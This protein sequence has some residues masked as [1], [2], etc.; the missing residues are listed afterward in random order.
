[1]VMVHTNRGLCALGPSD[2]LHAL[3]LVISYPAQD[4]VTRAPLLTTCN[5][6]ACV[7]RPVR[8]SY[9][10]DELGSIHFSR[11]SQKLI[12]IRYLAS[13][14]LVGILSLSLYPLKKR[15]VSAGAQTASIAAYRADLVRVRTL[16]SARQAPQ[17]SCH[18]GW[19]QHL[20]NP[21]APPKPQGLFYG[22]QNSLFQVWQR[23]CKS[24]T[25]YLR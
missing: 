17:Y 10:L 25:Q 16:L 6:R 21:L 13:E 15:F 2:S 11:E 9:P 19:L 20:Y 18:D 24:L 1:M 8:V 3:R 4:S 23:D 22:L 7:L 12:P 14:C 5:P